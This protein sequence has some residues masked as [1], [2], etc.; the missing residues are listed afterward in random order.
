MQINPS[1]NLMCHCMRKLQ[2]QMQHCKVS[3]T[4]AVVNETASG[5]DWLSQKI[6]RCHT[7]GNSEAVNCAKQAIADGTLDNPTA[8][9]SAAENLMVWG[10]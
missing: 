4:D 1:D 9:E 10:I 5:L 6:L 3:E 7:M 2:Q 8:F